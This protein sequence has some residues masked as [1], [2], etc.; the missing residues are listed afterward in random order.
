MMSLG[1]GPPAVF[2]IIIWSTRRTVHATSVARRS[3]RLFTLIKSKILASLVS[4]GEPSSM[5]IPIEVSPLACNAATLAKASVALAP[6]FSAI[7]RGTTSR[8]SLYFLIEYCSSPGAASPI[9]RSCRAISIS[10]APAPATKRS[11]RSNPRYTLTASSTA[12]SISSRRF[13]VEPL[14]RMVAIRE[15]PFSW[16]KMIHFVEPISSTVTSSQNPISSLFGACSFANATA[17]VVRAI[18]LKSNLDT[19]LTA[20]I[21]YF[22][23]KCMLISLNFGAARTVTPASDKLLSFSSRESSSERLYFF[24][25]SALCNRTVPLVSDCDAS[26]SQV[27]IAIFAFLQC[28]TV[29]WESPTSTVPRTTLLSR[30]EAPR[31]F[32]TRTFSTENICTLGG[33]VR[34]HAWATSGAMI[35]SS[36]NCLLATVDRST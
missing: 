30:I 24:S 33:S 21:L 20:M 10:A 22:S 4:M 7:V 23:M 1:L 13:S 6:A 11:S 3:A 28:L 18:L 15:S 5:L 32:A 34:I 16:R 25:S 14:R 29:P 12:L 9:A 2:A 26:R 8:A 27:K 17:P 36:P 31:T 35:S 19:H